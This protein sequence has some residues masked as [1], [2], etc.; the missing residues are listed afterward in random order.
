[1]MASFDR[2]SMRRSFISVA[3]TTPKELITVLR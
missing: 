1:L 2:H 3:R